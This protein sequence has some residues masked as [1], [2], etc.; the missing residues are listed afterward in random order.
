M[1]G[2]LFS[3]NPYYASMV[4]ESLLLVDKWFRPF[5]SSMC[6]EF[7]D[8]YHSA[9]IF[10]ELHSIWLQWLTAITHLHLDYNGYRSSR[11]CQGDRNLWIFQQGILDCIFFLCPIEKPSSSNFK[12]EVGKMWHI[13]M[14]WHSLWNTGISPVGWWIFKLRVICPLIVSKGCCRTY[15]R[16]LTFN[17]NTWML[18]V[19]FAS[20]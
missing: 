20:Q 16:L 8:K 2:D 3:L 1:E 9:S 12:E 5:V 11:H 18:I 14:V 13:P 15:A 10:V 17:F 4:L 7:R 19:I 6:W